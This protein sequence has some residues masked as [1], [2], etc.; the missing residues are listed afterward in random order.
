MT[1]LNT[2][3]TRC[4]QPLT[5]LTT[6]CFVVEQPTGQ[7]LTAW[8]LC[9]TCDDLVSLALPPVMLAPLTEAGCHVV[10]VEACVPYPEQRPGGAPLGADDVLALHEL[11]ADED[12]LAA[13][14]DELGV[15]EA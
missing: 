4:G 2:A 6:A 14:V 15:R 12:A 11:L 9:P 8:V 5:P 1:M 7:S 13:A 10:D 3:C